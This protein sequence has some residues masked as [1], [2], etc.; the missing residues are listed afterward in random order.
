[1]P[2]LFV[3]GFFQLNGEEGSGNLGGVS[4]NEKFKNTRG[5]L[6]KRASQ[7]QRSEDGTGEKNELVNEPV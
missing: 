3:G 7:N 1:M 4:G 6:V 2:F 5:R